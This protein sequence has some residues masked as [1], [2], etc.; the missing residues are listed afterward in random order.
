VHVLEDRHDHV[1]VRD[2]PADECGELREGGAVQVLG[3]RARDLLPRAA[4]NDVDDARFHQ[5][6]DL[7]VLDLEVLGVLAQSRLRVRKE[8]RGLVAACA[9]GFAG[10]RGSADAETLAAFDAGLAGARA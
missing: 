5:F 7:Q 10:V 1:V 3:H 2:V 9:A 8:H 6:P 4:V